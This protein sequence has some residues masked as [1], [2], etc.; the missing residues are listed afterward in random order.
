MAQTHSPA[1]HPARNVVGPAV[2]IEASHLQRSSD[3]HTSTLK[4][5]DADQDLLRLLIATTLCGFGLLVLAVL[6][7]V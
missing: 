2:L 6:R 4:H 1:S 3:E 5:Q 7:Q